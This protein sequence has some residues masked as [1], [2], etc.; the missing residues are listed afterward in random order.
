[1]VAERPDVARRFVRAT[2]EG[3][4]SYLK[5]DPAP[6]NALIKADNPKM[7]DEQI[8]FGIKRLNQLEV[9]D[10]GDAKTMGIGIITAARWKASYELMVNEGLLPKETD[11]TKGFTTEFVK[12]LKI[13]T[14]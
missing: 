4:K 14:R 7:S 2:I 9:A 5:G 13:T 10:G 3:W 12:G 6:A 11:W 8:A 1:L